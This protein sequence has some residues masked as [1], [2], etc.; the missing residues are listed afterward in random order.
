MNDD[1]SLVFGL[2]PLMSSMKAG[3][4]S[5]SE[6]QGFHCGEGLAS[7]ILVGIPET[8]PA[9]SKEHCQAVRIN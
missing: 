9:H 1:S 7:F 2:E 6:E 8:S 3:T 5:C 4:Q